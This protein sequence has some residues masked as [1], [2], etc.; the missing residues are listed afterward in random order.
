[1]ASNRSWEPDYNQYVSQCW[2]QLSP[3]E[4]LQCLNDEYVT[5]IDEFIN[6]QQDTDTLHN[7]LSRLQITLGQLVAKYKSY[8]TIPTNKTL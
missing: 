7:V 8:S 6:E 4:Q 5:G 2:G 3:I 1:M